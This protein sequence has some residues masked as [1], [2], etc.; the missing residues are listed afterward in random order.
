MTS[1]IPK[2]KTDHSP[3]LLIVAPFIGI[4]VGLFVAF[5][6]VDQNK[7]EPSVPEQI[8]TCPRPDCDYGYPVSEIEAMGI[9][10]EDGTWKDQ[11]PQCDTIFFVVEKMVPVYMTT[12]WTSDPDKQ[13][14]KAYP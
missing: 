12:I 10:Q 11:C 3:Y 6:G 5:Y 8:V 2:T 7:K 1:K 13:D 4:T 14:A 9:L